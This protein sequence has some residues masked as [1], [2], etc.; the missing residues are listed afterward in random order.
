MYLS[1][2][3]TAR[4]HRLF[5]ECLDLSSHRLDAWITSFATYRLQQMRAAKPTGLTLGGYGWVEWKGS[6]VEPIQQST[7]YVQAPSLAH[8]ATAA[9]LRSGYLSHNADASGKL[10]ALDLSSRRV[11][12]AT[13][14]ME[15][16]RR[17]QPLGALLGYRFERMLAERSKTGVNLQQ[18]IDEF[19]ALAPLVAHKMSNGNGQDGA[20]EA[21]AAQNVVDGLALLLKKATVGR[22][23]SP[24]PPSRKQPWRRCWKSWTTR[25]IASQ[26]WWWRRACIRR[27]WATQCTRGVDWR[28]SPQEKRPRLRRR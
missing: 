24:K 9:V 19:R 6:P 28:L 4:L 14:L 23:T 7:G 13:W 17:D 10:L 8:A 18:Y 25:W 1:T 2:L 3:P 22:G 16:I 12:T 20:V 26:T 11:R 21:V 5:S 27:C 15:G